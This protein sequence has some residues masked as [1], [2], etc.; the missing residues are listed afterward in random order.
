LLA[1]IGDKLVA[2]IGDKLMASIGDKLV[3]SIERHIGSYSNG[4]KLLASFG[5]NGDQSTMSVTDNDEAA[6]RNE[7]EAKNIVAASL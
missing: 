3:A 6:G 1:S 5:N 7:T 2:S 4:D